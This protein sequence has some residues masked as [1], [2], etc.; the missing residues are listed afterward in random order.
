MISD[1]HYKF[2]LGGKDLEMETI[3]KVLNRYFPKEFILNENLSWGAR[4]SSYSIYFNN[5]D[6]FI[7]VELVKDIAPPK[8]YIEIDHHNILSSKPSSL[9][10]IIS[11]LKSTFKIKIRHSRFLQLVSANDRGYIPEMQSIGA[12]KKEIKKI[13]KAD[14]K[15]QGVTEIDELMAQK[16]IIENRKLIN[17]ITIIKSFSSKFSPII[18]SLYPL[19]NLLIYTDKELTFYG[20]LSRILSTYYGRF[21]VSNKAYSGGGVNG[22]FGFTAEG[23]N[24]YENVESVVCEILKVLQN[25]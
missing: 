1:L 11:L 25:E 18:D 22:F 16:S 8:N 20:S 2:L 3:E 5:D 9:D 13:R 15:A 17:G 24:S 21:L 10:Q 4:L 14:R 7:G 12:S 23:I 19:D 6:T